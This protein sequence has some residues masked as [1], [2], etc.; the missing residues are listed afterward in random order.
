M[1]PLPPELLR[2]FV[3]VAKAGSFT[4]AS[5]RV[6]LSQSTVSQHVRRL[7]EL[8]DR[9]LFERDTRNVRLSRHG[10]ELHRYATRILDLMD[11][12]VASVCGPPLG[13][14]VRL[15]L[16]EDFASTRLTT[17]LAS[18]MRRN[19][20]VELSITTGLS[21][22]LFRDLDEERYDLVLAK[23]LSGSLR[24]R[25]IRAE[26]LHWCVGEDSIID[27]SEAVLPLALHPE[28][29][30]ARSRVLEALKAADRPYKVVITSGSIAVLKAAVMA[31]LGISAFG[32]YVIPQGLVR[33]EEGLP[34]LGSLD[35][36][37][38]R[39]V[40]ISPAATAL[41]ATLT[42]VAMEL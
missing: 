40:A 25:V 30:I 9:P 8:L 28:P 17:A 42:A 24:G 7:E 33:L 35:Y 23:R 27:G 5:E 2:S 14:P 16:S 21:G 6:Y 37:I 19:P 18:F 36:V 39:P 11:E 1:R 29:S 10:E 3:A 31:G 15:G 22:D 4:A 12:A 41:E 13:G 26:P 20:D 34:D 32:G 38:D